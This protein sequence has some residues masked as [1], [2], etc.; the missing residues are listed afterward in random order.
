[1]IKKNNANKNNIKISSFI[2]ARIGST[3]LNSK[4]L[5]PL[6]DKRVLDYVLEASFSVFPEDTILVIPDSKENDILYKEYKNV[7]NVFRGSENDVLKRFLDCAEHTHTDF[8]VRICSDNPF[9]QKRFIQKIKSAAEKNDC[10]Y[11]S[12]FIDDINCITKAFGLYAEGFSVKKAKELYEGTDSFQ[13]EH[14][15]PAFYNQKSECKILKLIPPKELLKSLNIRFTLD[16]QNDY[17]LYK[18]IVKNNPM[19]YYPY[20]DLLKIVSSNKDIV[21]RM[22]ENI[23]KG[24]K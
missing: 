7:M 6:G 20:K 16:N 17:D 13:R 12:Y 5:K 11:I 19:E 15:T 21:N 22:K 4:V 14:V 8:I 23:L 24:K 2:Q 9:I 1:M 10:D 18:L 3:R